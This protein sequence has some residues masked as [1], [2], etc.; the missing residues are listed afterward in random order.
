MSRREK[1][2]AGFG[3]AA[4]VVFIGLIIVGSVLSRR[5]EPFVRAQ[6]EQYLRDRFRADVQ[7]ATLRVHLPPISPLRMLF[8]GGHGSIA[9]V[10]GKDIVMR[11]RGRP[12]AAPLFSIREFKTDIDVGALRDSSK[13]VPLVRITGLEIT[14]PPK[15]Q[16]PDLT[17][18]SSPADQPPEDP[19]EPK[20]AIVIDR[21]NIQKAAL[22][23]MPA[24]RTKKP[25]R[26]DIHDVKMQS[27]GQGVAMQYDCFLTNASPPGEIHSTGTF[28][29][30]NT[31][32]PGDTP[33]NGDFSFDHA[34]LGVYNVIAGILQSKGHFQ[35]ELDTITAR[36]EAYVPDFRLKRS[37]NPVP[38]RT[39]Y[40]V[41]VDGTNGNTTLKPV[42]ATLGATRFTTSGVV[43]KHDGD[44]H[45][46]I[47]LQ[48]NM[49]NG[50]MQ[51]VLRLAM[52][53][54]T[55]M[56]GTLQLKTMLELPN[57]DGKVMNKLR[58]DGTFDITNGHFL[59]STIQD[60]IDTLSQRGQGQPNNQEIDE[61]VS[62]MTGSFKLDEHVITFRTL[63]FG[64]S[65][66][67]VDLAGSYDLN[68]DALDFHGALRLRAKVSQTVTG[69]KHWLLKP[70]DPFLAKNGAGTYL[71]IQVVGTSKAPKFGRERNGSDT[72][73]PPAGNAVTAEGNGKQSS[74]QKR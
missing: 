40:E 64:V 15:G 28:G 34:D 22:I 24:D 36:G 3:A 63:T 39:K 32:E 58:L 56:E 12:A 19:S 55:F 49:P 59:R 73:K 1:Y 21:L 37:G 26:F 72:P 20:T 11:M 25:L 23:L 14:V 2:V 68:A 50:R 7:I 62:R 10:E 35:G 42:E 18:D 65:G 43:F 47:H 5:I 52:K 8:T 57:L 30:W 44:R 51:D 13:H 27:A 71:K 9:T 6:A 74:T 45:R 4:I 16:R 48:V 17:P 54:D 66:A 41:L 53:G 31:T 61:V 46:Q 38:L 69:W 67:D 60:Q 29:P 33:L 70:V